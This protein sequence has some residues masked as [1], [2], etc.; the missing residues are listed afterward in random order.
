VSGDEGGEGVGRGLAPGA[1]ELGGVGQCADIGD[2]HRAA[3]VDEHFDERGLVGRAPEQRRRERD[4]VDVGRRPVRR[5]G[6]RQGPHERRLQHGLGDGARTVG[7]AD[8]QA[9]LH[10]GRSCGVGLRH[11][12][13]AVEHAGEALFE[14]VGA[15]PEEAGD[16][17]H[18]RGRDDGGHGE[19]E[20]D[21]DHH[22]ERGLHEPRT[23]VR[24]ALLGWRAVNVPR[25]SRRR[26]LTGI[27]AAVGLAA[28]KAAG[29][30]L[31]ATT[32]V[33]PSSSTA[34]RPTAQ[35]STAPAPSAPATTGAASTSPTG[36]A[37]YVPHGPRTGNEVS[38]T[39]HASG[40]R[41]LAV[42][43]LDLLKRHQTTV[44]VFAV[45]QWL[46]A[47]NDLAARIRADGHE[48]GNHTQTHQAMG[49]LSAT[50]VATEI[51]GC[52]DVLRQLT[53]SISSWFRPS[54]IDVPTARILQQAGQ[55]GYATSVGYDIDSLDFQ[56]P[57][58]KAVVANVRRNLQP[59]AII[60]LHFGHQGTIDAL[61]SLLDLLKTS[62]LRPVTVGELLA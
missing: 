55:A 49:T 25:P 61:P 21:A 44:T 5:A 56:D 43:L 9:G 1:Q 8:A 12:A 13:G 59:G 52:A 20:D 33:T 22:L 47:N 26:I 57:G 30:K 28:C 39:F 2:Q 34:S 51:T 16:E 24:V 18:H 37:Q 23:L 10:A 31:A 35:T 41:T 60:S 58:A 27:A 4:R 19:R 36:P 17:L 11:L 29:S 42:E 15:H 54:G 46:A 50:S 32:T 53:G 40:D 38:L 62:G 7:H 45:G 3:P 6:A 48:F 14:R